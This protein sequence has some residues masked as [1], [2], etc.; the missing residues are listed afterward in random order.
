MGA[1][2]PG[3]PKELIRSPALADLA[4]LLEWAEDE[5]RTMRLRSAETVGRPIGS[6]Q[7]L[8]WLEFECGRTLTAKRGLRGN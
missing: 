7:F 1:E 6:E 5:K 3:F 8:E 2:R 4:G